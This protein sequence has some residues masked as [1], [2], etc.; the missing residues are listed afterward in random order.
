MM[1]MIVFEHKV[2]VEI[3]HPMVSVLSMDCIKQDFSPC[4]IVHNSVSCE[5]MLGWEVGEGN[6]SLVLFLGMYTW[7]YV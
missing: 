7:F 3:L 6:A 2:E 4:N 5:N 1:M